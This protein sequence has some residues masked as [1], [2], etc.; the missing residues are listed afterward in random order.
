MVCL[1]QR[2]VFV[3]GGDD[4]IYVGRPWRRIKIFF[5]IEAGSFVA[6]TSLKLSI[7]PKSTEPSG[8]ASQFLEL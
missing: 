4:Y 5:L 8:S 6:Q 1:L 3:V 2:E 7:Y